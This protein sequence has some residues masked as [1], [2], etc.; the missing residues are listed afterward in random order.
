M[1]NFELIKERFLEIT[2]QMPIFSD[3]LY[4]Q[5]QPTNTVA[6]TTLTIST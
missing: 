2:G 5:E 1:R 4:E 6:P 3:N